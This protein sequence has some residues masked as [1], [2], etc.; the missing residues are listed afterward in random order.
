MAKIN[1]KQP[2]TPIFTH[3]GAPAV[4]ISKLAELRRSV[5]SCLL[6]EDNFYEDGVAISARIAQLAAEVDPVAVAALAV[7]ARH[8]FKLRHV[9]LLLLEALTHTAAGRPDGLISKTME[10]VIDRADEMTEFLAIYHKM[11]G[12]T[13]S[14]QVKKGLALAFNKFDAYG[15]KKYDREASWKL[16]DVVFLSHVKPKDKDHSLTVAR[17]VNKERFPGN[18]K[19]STY[20][21]AASL[22]PDTFEK[23]KPADTWE[24]NLSAGKDKKEYWTEVLEKT[25]APEFV[26]GSLGYLALLRNLRNMI[27]AGV[28]S[29][30]IRKAL[31]KR[32][33]Y[34]KVLPFRYVAAAKHAPQFEPELDAALIASVEASEPLP[35]STIVLVDV[36]GSMD[37]ALSGKSELTR[38]DAAAVLGSIIPGH[39]RVFTFS[40]TTMEVP[41]RRGMAGVDAI[42]RS[43]MHGGTNLGDAMQHVNALKHD[44]LIVITDE[45]SHQ[46]VPQPV[47][48]KAYMINVASAKNGVGY[49]GNWTHI[50]GFSE[51]VLRYIYEVEGLASQEVESED[52]EV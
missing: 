44:R 46:R 35:G 28:D 18:T 25:A 48:K 3:E 40:Y 43:Q 26:K 6:F 39:V 19:A 41:P 23:L 22:H 5:L 45:Q 37:A 7:E 27:Q 24:V 9:P 42:K 4:K 33:G 21:V 15:L 29:D 2:S 11:G 12:K 31:N 1:V 30:L 49:G 14:G 20:P 36:S 47:A 8:R 17:L 52:A 51:S 16:R 32:Q 34:R 10:K 13:L 50:D 38:M